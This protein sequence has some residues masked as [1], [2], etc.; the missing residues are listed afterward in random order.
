M[1]AEVVMVFLGCISSISLSF[2]PVWFLGNPKVRRHQKV[3][4]QVINFP[5]HY[6]QYNLDF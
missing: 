1:P 2:C 3:T 4:G 6:P 5:A